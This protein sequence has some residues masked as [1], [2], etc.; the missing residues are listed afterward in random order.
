MMRTI[1]SV[2]SGYAAMFIL[3]MTFFTVLGVME[4]DAFSS[5]DPFPKDNFLLLVVGFTFFSSL[6]GGI[7]ACLV[8]GEAPIKHA[9]ILSVF[10]TVMGVVM[11]IASS[12]RQP[13]ARHL[14]M[15]ALTVGGIVCGA[16]IVKA[17]RPKSAPTA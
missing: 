10:V 1:M 16:L 12:A 6:V 3:T 7:V 17:F 9:I 8:A 2:V 5:G 13:V 11:T 4:P 14:L 15:I